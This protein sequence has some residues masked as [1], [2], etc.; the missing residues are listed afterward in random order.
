MKYFYSIIILLLLFPIYYIYSST[1]VVD[2]NGTGNYTT[3]QEG[4]N[5]SQD[6]DIVLIYPGTYFENIDYIG[7]N[8]TVA[9]KYYTTGDESYIKNTII[10]GNNNG[11]CV[12]VK[13]GGDEA[14]IYGLTIQNG[15]GY[16]AYYTYGGGI[17]I[18]EET[19][20]TFNITSCIIT[21]NHADT[22]GGIFVNDCLEINISG[23]KIIHNFAHSAGGGF[24]KGN[25]NVD[26]N[27]SSQDLCDI[28][29]NYS[30][31]GS[32]IYNHAGNMIVY[33]DT[34]TVNEPD[35]FYAYS[36][37]DNV[38]IIANNYKIEQINN[39]VYVS[40]NGNNSNSGLHWN[41]AYK[42]IYY[43]LIMIKS[44]SLRPKKIYVDEGTYS[45]S[46]TGDFFAIGG[47]DYISLLGAGKECTIFDAES[48][49]T[50]IQFFKKSNYIIKDCTIFNGKGNWVGG[51]GVCYNSSFKIENVVIKHNNCVSGVAQIFIHSECDVIF[52]NVDIIADDDRKGH[53]IG[54]NVNVSLMA[55]NCEFKGNNTSRNRTTF[56]ACEFVNN[57]TPVF[58]NT[59][60]SNYCGSISSGIAM[61]WSFDS[62]FLINCTVVDN[63][64]CSEGT[65][66][67]VDDSH[68]TLINTI[69]RNESDTEIWFHP[70][71]AP[72]SAYIEYCN[73]EGGIDAINTNNN[74]TLYWGDGNI[75]E[76]PL[77]VGGDPFSYELTKYSPC[78]D[79][80]T[81]DTTGLHLPAT[82]LAGNPRIF[83]GRIDIGAYECQDTVSVDEPDT[84]FID[85]LYLFQNTPNPFTNETEIL[86][87][88]A[89]YERVE[90][91]TLSIYNTKGQLVRRFDGRTNNFW[92]K[93]KIVWDGTDERGKHVAP[94][95]YL[96]KLEYNGHAV[97]RKMVKITSP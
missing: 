50:T 18:C 21:S 72:S 16:D 13:D 94:G 59:T 56:G 63:K 62:M 92:V 96:Y 70:T 69:L 14:T 31:L 73:I 55:Y 47:K 3:I 44:D 61:L 26:V 38:I 74:G 30:S 51:M 81:P 88:T 53:D 60:L 46:T 75:D 33:V 57:T 49:A 65:I 54:A 78:I 29:M 68:I 89:D 83:N 67:L 87:I 48:S 64:D 27:F 93:T 52:N 28:Y 85:N 66:R 45:P 76:D 2:I 40:P 12:V 84:S 20:N 8:I 4:I 1:I 32:D 11:S 97:V 9:S 5:N 79:A 77:F 39:D 86:F 90:D 42:N 58:I 7:K 36:R 23:T 71:G 43:A 41:D 80:G 37:E 34:F 24:D 35:E 17:Y 91:Y 19:I 25:D 6:G 15:S 10:D 82:D 22:G 95:T